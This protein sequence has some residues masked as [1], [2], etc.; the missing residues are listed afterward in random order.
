MVF[1]IDKYIVKL[2]IWESFISVSHSF[3]LI[4]ICAKI[5]AS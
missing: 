3:L 4:S 2:I 1:C 5:T